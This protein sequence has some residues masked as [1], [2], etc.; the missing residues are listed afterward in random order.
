MLTRAYLARCRLK[1]QRRA[2]QQL[3]GQI[4]LPATWF[5]LVASILRSFRCRICGVCTLSAVPASRHPQGMSLAA[6]LVRS[7]HIVRIPV[8]RIAHN[9][10]TSAPTW[11]LALP[12]LSDAQLDSMQTRYPESAGN[13]SRLKF[14]RQIARDALYLPSANQASSHIARAI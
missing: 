4:Y 6:V 10:F 3:D 13:V 7:V 12:A 11:R 14:L 5:C 1:F 8:Q 9:V 2:V